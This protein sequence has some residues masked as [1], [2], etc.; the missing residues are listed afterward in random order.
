[1]CN[2]QTPGKNPRRRSPR[3]R[4]QRLAKMMTAGVLAIIFA[5]ITNSQ[6]VASTFRGL[7]ACLWNTLYYILL[8]VAWRSTPS[9][10]QFRN[11]KKRD[12]KLSPRIIMP[13]NQIDVSATIPAAS[14]WPSL[15]RMQCKIQ[16]YDMK[17]FYTTRRS[18]FFCLRCFASLWQRPGGPIT[19][20]QCMGG[21]EY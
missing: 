18:S 7:Q 14:L 6:Q 5:S 17:L 2:H 8:S 19:Q 21:F 12:W 1:M 13:S 15:A 20:V 10:C 16:H 3:R 9:H 11:A 4:K